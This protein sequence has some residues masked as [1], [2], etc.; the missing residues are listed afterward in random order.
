[1]EGSAPAGPRP[2][3]DEDPLLAAIWH[4]NILIAAV[5]F[6]DRQYSVPVSRSRDG[7]LIAAVLARLGYASSPRGSSS[8]GGAA[9]LRGLVTRLKEGSSV[10][11]QT[12]GPRGPAQ[13]SKP[14]IVALARLSGVP[15]SPVGFAASSRACFRSWDRTRLPLPFSRVSCVIAPSIEISRSLGA[16]EREA[17]MHFLDAELNRLTDE[18]DRRMEKR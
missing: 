16:S 8:R 12:D 4:R 13:V 6:R 18:M 9:A 7:D 3:P 2:A 15:I 11:I 10:A 1:M 5:L 14:G 17:G